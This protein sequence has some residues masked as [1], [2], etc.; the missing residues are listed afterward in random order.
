MHFKL[1][2]NLGT[3]TQKLFAD[4]GHQVE[5]ILSEGLQGC[6]DQYLMDVCRAEKL[7]LVTLDMMGIP[8]NQETSRGL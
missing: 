8:L 1:D 4:A 3:R 2:E 5:T 7:C 6:S